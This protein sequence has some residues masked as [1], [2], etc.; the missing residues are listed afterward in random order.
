MS[1]QPAKHF[2]LIVLHMPIF[3]Y[4]KHTKNTDVIIDVLPLAAHTAQIKANQFVKKTI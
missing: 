4:K 3:T 1:H 2:V